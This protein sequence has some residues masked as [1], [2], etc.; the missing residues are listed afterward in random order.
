MPNLIKQ[1]VTVSPE[2]LFVKISTVLDLF[3]GVKKIVA[4]QEQPSVITTKIFSNS[5][6]N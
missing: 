1:S 3:F 6:K 2:E 4:K 5:P